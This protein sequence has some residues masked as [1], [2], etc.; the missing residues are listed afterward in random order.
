MP[1]ARP[2][3]DDESRFPRVTKTPEVVDA[4]LVP[5]GGEPETAPKPGVATEVAQPERIEARRVLPQPTAIEQITQ[6]VVETAITWLARLKRRTAY[7]IEHRPFRLVASAAAA[8]FSAGILLRLMRS[9]RR[10]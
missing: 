2:L 6:F 5:A 10:A 8:G 4:V 9:N 1:G 3:L 7:E